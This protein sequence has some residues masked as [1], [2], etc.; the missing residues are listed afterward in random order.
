MAMNMGDLMKEAQ[1][2]HPIVKRLIKM[3]QLPDCLIET[4]APTLAA[5]G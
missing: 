1:K 3:P 5:A 4:W 2:M